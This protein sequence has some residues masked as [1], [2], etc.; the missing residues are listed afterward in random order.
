MLALE[1]NLKWDWDFGFQ[2]WV[3]YNCIIKQFN[4]CKHLNVT[5]TVD[6]QP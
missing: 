5:K 3:L 1:I 4:N 6:C 2:I